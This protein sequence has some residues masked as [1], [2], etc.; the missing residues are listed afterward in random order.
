MLIF[1]L[2]FFAALFF[3]VRVQ[4]RLGCDKDFLSR[5]R[6]SALNGFFVLL[7]FLSHAVTYVRPAG[8][9][10]AS[11]LFVKSQLDQLVVAPFLFFSGYG[12]LCSI[13]D[14]GRAYVRSFPRRRILKVLVQSELAVLLFLAA[15]L[16][17]GKHYPLRRVL[18]SFTFWESVGN[19]N[20][21]LFVILALYVCVFVSFL[22]AGERLILGTALTSALAVGL[23]FALK[24][25]GKDPWWYNT[26]LL[27]P[28]G[29]WF[30]LCLP[31]LERAVFASLPRTLV[32]LGLC[33]GAFCGLRFLRGRGFVFY[34]LWAAA[35]MACVVLV[36]SRVR[37]DNALLR[38]FGRHV[39]A[40]FIL[41]RIPMLV[42]AHL[43]LAQHR[44]LFVALSFALTIF[45]ALGFDRCVE[46]V[47]FHRS[48]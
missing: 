12:V 42:F 41:Q 14:R 21:Y 15:D 48:K 11:Y 35:F 13:R 17:I 27:F 43:G 46:S 37:F 23:V 10:D 20:W 29:M 26:L 38:F 5:E 40:F 7:V 31:R 8:A 2:L 6:T 28:L 44:Y 39:F 9:L 45:L 18:L 4:P 34:E 22:L 32:S 16:C 47:I 36:M 19:S 25:A 33:A 1:L 3:G 30:G 24:F